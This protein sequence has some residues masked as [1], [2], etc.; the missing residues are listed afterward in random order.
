MREFGRMTGA[1]PQE[2]VWLSRA[3]DAAGGQ[4]GHIRKDGRT[5]A[6][7]GVEPLNR[8]KAPLFALLL[9]FPCRSSRHFDPVYEFAA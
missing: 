9:A 6:N 8:G 3:C 4:I 1:G 5:A 7:C 2:A